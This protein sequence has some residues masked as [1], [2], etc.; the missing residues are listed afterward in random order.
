MACQT[1]TR[2]TNKT[3]SVIRVFK[4]FKS[5]LFK[6]FKIKDKASAVTALRD[7]TKKVTSS[8]RNHRDH[9]EPQTSSSRASSIFFNTSN[10][11]VILSDPPRID[12]LELEIH[13]LKNSLKKE[14]RRH[15]NRS[16]YIRYRY[17]SSS[18]DSDL[19]NNKRKKISFVY[20]QDNKLFL[21]LAERY[22]TVDIKYFKQI[23]FGT[24]HPQSLPELTRDYTD[25][26]EVKGKKNDESHDINSLNR[27]MRCFDVYYQ[28][29]CYF[30]FRPNVVL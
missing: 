25:F 3:F 2:I 22:R 5:F 21:N 24:F 14:R 11:F 4:S 9:F 8:R 19:K 27:F 17:H 28:V 30:V 23:F 20:D 13:R 29:I 15:Y 6:A 16:R 1:R 18:P 7:I 26:T 10:T 12:R